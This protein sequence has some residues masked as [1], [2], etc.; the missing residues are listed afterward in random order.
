MVELGIQLKRKSGLLFADDFVGVSDSNSGS[1]FV[2]VKSGRQLS[3]D[4][5]KWETYIIY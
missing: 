3:T 4:L 1:K 2:T 5:K